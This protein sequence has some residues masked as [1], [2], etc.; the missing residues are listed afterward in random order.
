MQWGQNAQLN[1][2]EIKKIQP[3]EKLKLHNTI[4]ISERR[5]YLAKNGEIIFE[6]RESDDVYEPQMQWGPE[7]RRRAAECSLLHCEETGRED[8][9]VDG[10]RISECVREGVAT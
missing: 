4:I 2:W 6:E 1:N 5:P 8:S 3:N 9:P 7:W 10:D